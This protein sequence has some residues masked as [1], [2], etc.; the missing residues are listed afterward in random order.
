MPVE[1]AYHKGVPGG[2]MGIT[3]FHNRIIGTANFVPT[4]SC[5]FGQPT[6]LSVMNAVDAYASGL[7]LES[8]FRITRGVHGFIHYVYNNASYDSGYPL[9]LSP[10]HKVNLGILCARQ[11]SSRLKST[12]SL[13]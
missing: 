10:C 2:H 7:E 6:E 4:M 13:Y 12:K 9:Y 8:E 11:V 3:L 5:R 1:V